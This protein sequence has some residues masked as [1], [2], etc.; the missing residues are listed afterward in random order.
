MTALDICA[1][2]GDI[3]LDP[4]L[5]GG[6]AA[7]L[8]RMAALGLPVPPA[9][10]LTTAVWRH[11][12]GEITD[13]AS[14]LWSRIGE[15]IRALEHRTGRRFGA[16]TDPLLVSVRSGAHTS[17][18]GMMDTI[19]NVGLA[20]RPAG[21]S[22]I[23]DVRRRLDEQFERVL[24]SRTP[25]EPWH[26]LRA[27]VLGVLASWDTPRARAYRALHGISDDEGTAVVVQAMVFGN[28]DRLS[29]T[30]VLFTR[31][32]HTG[33]DTVYGEWLPQGQG[34]DVVSGRMNARPLTELAEAI[35]TAHRQLITAGALLEQTQRD[36]QDIE[37][38]IDAGRLWLLQTRTATQ[39]A[40]ARIRHAVRMAEEGVI[41]PADALDR[42]T[43]A[44]IETFLRPRLDPTVARTAT[45]LA[46]GLPAGPGIG[47]GTVSAE[48][49]PTDDTATAFVLARPTTA[50]EDVPAMSR[51]AAVVTDHGGVTSH[52]AVIC[53]D[54]GV[55]CV[56]G[57]GSDATDGLLGRIVTVD[58]YD[59]RIYD[60]IVAVTA[61]GT[62]EDPDLV[63]LARW[64]TQSGSTDT[65]PQLHLSVPR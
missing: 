22:F 8:N 21:D 49:P 65:W 3:D 28:R 19:L 25:D 16:V 63:T 57:C 44:D 33:T 53:R 20:H 31:D 42:V 17:M 37:F 46:H 27:A 12:H 5:V 40:E 34:E 18:P 62:P 41:E 54:L 50:P 55:V 60:G 64:A 61:P 56:V 52:A 59:G 30:G 23:V 7:S 29:G 15:H 2:D 47:V 39:S 9:F 32:P 38:T 13:P 58:G 43:D 51:A 10:V 6:K 24:G 35:P 1:L 11:R 26:Q 36:V 48:E 14:Q 45:V 4:H